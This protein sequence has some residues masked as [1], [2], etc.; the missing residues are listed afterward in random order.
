[1]SDQVP[2]RRV[3][4]Y[5]TI[6]QK[7]VSKAGH[8]QFMQDLV[9]RLKVGQALELVLPSGQKEL[10]AFCKSLLRSTDDCDALRLQMQPKMRIMPSSKTRGET[11]VM[12][13]GRLVLSTRCILRN[14]TGYTHIFCLPEECLPADS[15]QVQL[16]DVLNE[17]SYQDIPA[18]EQAKWLQEF[19]ECFPRF[20]T[21]STPAQMMTAAQS[22]CAHCGAKGKL[23]RCDS[24]LI[25]RYCSRECFK[26]D[27]S[28]HKTLL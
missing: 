25:T 6:V 22:G 19:S 15:Y 7:A 4:V 24:C 8:L 10:D 23:K 20:R 14:L 13:K 27:R 12:W 1:M 11:R 21:A 26:L 2:K 18:N 28:V 5:F 3:E 9:R 17:G 16:L